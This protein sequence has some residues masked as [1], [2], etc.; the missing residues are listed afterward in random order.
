M[1]QTKN[2][3]LVLLTIGVILS[4]FMIVLLNLQPRIIVRNENGNSFDGFMSDVI[5]IKMDRNGYPRTELLSPTFHYYRTKDNITIDK[6]RMLINPD[7]L[8]V[9]GL[10]ITAD[11]AIAFLTTKTIHLYRNVIITRNQNKHSPK[12]KFLTSALTIEPDQNKAYTHR[13]VTIIQPENTLTAKGLRA[14]LKTGVISFVSHA[15]G[16][17]NPNTN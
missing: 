16:E 3:F 6:P 4:G 13:Q 8:H 11:Q 14:N 12:T 9:D 17:F 5:A 10:S 15:S 1:F 2:I 7:N